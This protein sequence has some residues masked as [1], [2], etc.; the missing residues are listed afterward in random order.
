MAGLQ[1]PTHRIYIQVRRGGH[2]E[3]S[4]L[5][6][7]FAFPHTDGRGF[8]VLLQTLP[9]DGALVLREWEAG[10]EED[11]PPRHRGKFR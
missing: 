7:G 4:W 9:L 1:N 6:V 5:N 8:D 11:T 10:V 2:G 3:E